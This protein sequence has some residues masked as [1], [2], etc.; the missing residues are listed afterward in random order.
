[1]QVIIDQVISHI[2]AMDANLAPETMQRLVTAVL[3]AVRAE[4]QH[5]ARVAEEN[6]L[7]NYQQRNRPWEA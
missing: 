4:A 6:S 1:M 2:R 5:E 7:Q 3:E